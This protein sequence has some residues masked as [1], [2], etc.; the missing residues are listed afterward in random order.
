MHPGQRGEVRMRPALAFCLC[1]LGAATACQKAPVERIERARD[2]VFNKRPQQALKEYRLAQD[3]LEGD[4]S[5]VSRPLLPRALLGQAEVY[6][7]ELRDVRQAVPLYREL[8]AKAPESD[9]ALHAHIALAE[10]LR[11]HYRDL[12]GAITELT[13]ALARDPV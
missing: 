2:A 6:Y 9:E 3:S 5:P 4:D 13:V 8:I 10:I 11:A 1:L 12:R 7:L